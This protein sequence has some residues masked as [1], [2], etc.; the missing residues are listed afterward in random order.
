MFNLVEKLITEVC[1]CLTEIDKEIL[2]R[3]SFL[4]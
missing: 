4:K 3:W 2:L 1:D